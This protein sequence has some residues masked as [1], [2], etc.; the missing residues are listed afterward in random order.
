MLCKAETFQKLHLSSETFI[1]ANAWNAGSAVILEEAG[2][3]AI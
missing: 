2:F 3:K 1:M